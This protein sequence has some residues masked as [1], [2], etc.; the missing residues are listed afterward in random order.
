MGGGGQAEWEGRGERRGEE[1]CG[2]RFHSHTHPSSHHPTHPPFF[3][4][5]FFFAVDT[6]A[7]LLK[8]NMILPGLDAPTAGPATV[9]AWTVDVLRRTIPACVP[10]IHFLS[11]GMS[12]EESTLNLQALQDEAAKVPGGV[13]WALTFSYG[14]ALQS[15][16][17]KTWGGDAAN[18]KAAQAILVALARA[19][20][21]A[22]LGKYAGPHPVPGGGR[23]LQAL[24]LGG[25]GK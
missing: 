24:R 5:F 17:L 7:I 25:A 22:Q 16:T 1:G 11:G 3:C 10:G 23:I 8:P 20:S 6:S 19:N 12:E 2:A 18:V 13:P 15:T 21:E 4:F 9:A 14:R